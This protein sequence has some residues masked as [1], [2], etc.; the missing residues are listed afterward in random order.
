MTETVFAGLLEASSLQPPHLIA[1]AVTEHAAPLGVLRCVIYLSDLRQSLLVPMRGRQTEGRES[2][3]VDGT[4]AGLAYRVS[5]VFDTQD[6]DGRTQVWLPLL[7]G[8]DRLGVLELLV[9]ELDDSVSARLRMLA[10]VTALILV[11]K[12]AYGDT[13]LQTRRLEPVQLPAELEW[14]FMPPLTFATEQVVVSGLL[15]PAYEVGG[16]AFDYAL[17]QDTL[18]VSMFD[19]VGHDLEAGL[20]SSVAMAACRNSRRADLDLHD[21]VQTID[22]T[23]AARF[24]DRFATAILLQLHLPT[25]TLRWVNC[26][27]P[28]PLLVRDGRVVK[29]LDSGTG[30]PHRPPLGLGPVFGVENPGPDQHEQLQPG[31]RVLLYT[32]GIVEARSPDGVFFGIERLTDFILRHAAEQMPAPETLRRLMRGILDHHDERL[33]DDATIVLLE[34]RPPDAGRNLLP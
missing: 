26:G 30:K 18:H 2:L 4:L 17:L 29:V 6:D 13:Y 8:A 14:A 15:E 34:W 10:S 21:M 25:G 12:R 1:D 31:D 27:H 28:P 7:D 32:D 24:A 22:D 9:A 11:S 19:A 16:D 3:A 33:S 20:T 23:L 5:K